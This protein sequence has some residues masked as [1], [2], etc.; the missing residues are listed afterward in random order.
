[1]ERTLC[2][3]VPGVAEAL[4]QIRS[5]GTQVVFVSDTDRSSA[6]L[7]DI[8]RS[9]GIFVDGDRLV[10]SCEEN[11]TK[12]DGTLLPAVFGTRSRR[13]RRQAVWHVGNH[14]WADVTMAAAAGLRPIPMLDADLTR[15]ER[16]MADRSTGPGPA[17]AAAARG[18]RLAIDAEWRAGTLDDRQAAIRTLGAEVAG[19][20]MVGFM[21]WAAEQCRAESVAHVGFLA[22]DGELPLEVARAMPGDHWSGRSLRYIQA[23]RFTWSLASAA[24]LGVDQWLKVGTDEEDGFLH[25]K[26][27]HIPFDAL[28]ARVGLQPADL[29]GDP[30]N[31]GLARLDPGRPLPQSAVEDWVGLLADP[32]VHELIGERAENRLSLIVDRLRADGL[33]AGRYALVD[34][35]WRGRLATQ[36]SAVLS[37]VVGEEPIHL[38]FG[39]DKVLPDVDACDDARARLGDRLGVSAAAANAVYARGGGGATPLALPELLDH[40]VAR[41]DEIAAVRV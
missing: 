23:S 34:V 38:H 36:V 33:P 37:Q 29:S 27:H 9:H 14:L 35:G 28:L 4:D 6:L 7:I 18:A 41:L 5:T 12:S 22:R 2:K 32:R 31:R 10:A 40:L 26:R 30:S 3:P 13:D 24:A 25:S 19:Q 17:V 8:L 15:Y 20:T 1:L 21:L 16:S 39:G 11:A